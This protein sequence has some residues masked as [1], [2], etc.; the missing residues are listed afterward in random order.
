MTN[1]E[2]FQLEELL[3]KLKA[4]KP[5]LTVLLAEVSDEKIDELQNDSTDFYCPLLLQIDICL[6]DRDND[7]LR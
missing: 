7:V 6:D 2:L 4:E 1:R 3:M 5:E